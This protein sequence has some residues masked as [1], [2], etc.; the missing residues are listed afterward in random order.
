MKPLKDWPRWAQLT[1]LLAVIYLA[2]FNLPRVCT[3]LWIG[4]KCL[5]AGNGRAGFVVFLTITSVVVALAI[6]TA[7]VWLAGQALLLTRKLGYGFLLAMFMIPAIVVPIQF[8]TQWS[9]QSQM[10]NLLAG[11]LALTLPVS[12]FLLLLGLAWFAA[13]D[14]VTVPAWYARSKFA[15]ARPSAT[16][17]A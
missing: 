17:P 3:G 16:L 15:P 5:L 13:A 7:S 9:R 12:Q 10:P 14:G 6:W 11:Q 2:V 4:G 1:G 8:F